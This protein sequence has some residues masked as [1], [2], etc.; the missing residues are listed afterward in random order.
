MLHAANTAYLVSCVSQK[1][2]QACEARDLYISDLFRKARRFS[3]ASGCP[4]FI[5]SAEHGLVTP[6][7]VIAPYDRTLNTMGVGDRRVWADRVA[8]QL[9]DAIPDLSQVVFL[10]G[11]RYREFLA[12]HLQ[13]RGVVVS[14]PMEG[15]RIGEQLSWL[16]QHSPRSAV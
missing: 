4:W 7:Q 5:L 15:L 3:E 13:R 6:N 11:K 12:L 14:V 9:Y 1:R 2:A 10:A 8:T 16:G